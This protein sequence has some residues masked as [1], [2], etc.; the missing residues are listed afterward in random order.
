MT[1]KDCE[2]SV[3]QI[4]FS[5]YGSWFNLSPITAKH[6]KSA[7]V[8]L[9]SH[10]NG[11]H[12]VLRLVPVSEGER[13]DTRV[14]GRPECLTWESPRGSIQA[15]YERPDTLRVRGR[16]VGLEVGAADPELTPFSGTYLYRDPRDGAFVF[17]SYETG[18]RYRVTVLRG[19]IATVSGAQGLGETPRGVQ[20]A[21]D[22][23]W[24]I[25]I[26]EYRTSRSSYEPVTS[27]D[28][29]VEAVARQFTI[30]AEATVGRS[31][32]VAPAAD[33][34]SYVLWSATVSP[35]GFVT[36]PS[37]LMSKHWMDKVWSWDHCFNAI[38]LA[39]GH[40]ELAWH[41]FMAVFDHQDETGALPDSVTHSEILYNFVKP[42]IHGWALQQ[43]RSRLRSPLSLDQ[44]ESVYERLSAWTNFWLTQRRAPGRA[45]PYY[46]HGNDSGW[47]NA[48][49]F[50]DERLVET[51]DLAGFLIIQLD[52]LA[53]LATETGRELESRAWSELAG[54]LFTAVMDELWDG[55][56]FLT[57]GVE[58]GR[59]W[60]SDSLLD[61]IPIVLGE[62][63][64][65]PVSD[66]L[67]K[68]LAEHHEAAGL[69]TE[70]KTS[71]YYEA[72]GY[73]RG[74]VWAPATILIEDGLR[75]AGHADLAD[76]IS[77]RFQDACEQSGFAENFNALTGEGLRDRA[78]TWTASAY[79]LLA[80]G[81]VQRAREDAGV[82]GTTG[83]AT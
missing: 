15:T 1:V 50:A 18:G 10:R 2:F 23:E 63:L 76:E 33:L 6:T 41:Q 70:L 30:F 46:Q 56:R 57:R 13:T 3:E 67:A 44:L 78:Y 45:L 73:W 4:P 11:M 16:G 68:H 60:R 21:D 51:A 35:A 31:G 79:L 39:A 49:P 24:E 8:H 17:T 9:V 59:R 69:A 66:V 53:G 77:E 19:E 14:V 5:H 28:D 62:R 65:P 74:P 58:S 27:F 20:L 12:P 36:R 81:Q 75:R 43:V 55:E 25:V 61:M 29:V 22:R 82:I 64:P 48:T 40:S 7:D 37:V 38:A 72:D 54:E 34:A 83:E 80:A 71:P 32:I 26:E 42:P 52:T 47:D